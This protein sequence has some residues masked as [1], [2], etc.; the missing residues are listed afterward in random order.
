MRYDPRRGAVLTTNTVAFGHVSFRRGMT[1]DIATEAIVR[2]EFNPHEIILQ[3][4]STRVPSWLN[5]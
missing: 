5:R 1:T 3:R 4:K 2:K